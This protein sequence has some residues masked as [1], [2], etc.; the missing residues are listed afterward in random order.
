[1]LKVKIILLVLFSLSL[2][3]EWIDLGASIP[4]APN[5]SISSTNIDNSNLIFELKGYSLDSHMIDNIEYL[6]NY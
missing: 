1:M 3:N 4:T 2:S 6:P 5:M